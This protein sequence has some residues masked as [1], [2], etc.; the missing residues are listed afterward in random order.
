M[1]NISQR[2]GGQHEI[3]GGR[4]D[5]RVLQ[6]PFLCASWRLTTYFYTWSCLTQANTENVTKDYIMAKCKHES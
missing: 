5:W 1:W 3:A 2:R 6:L 4:A